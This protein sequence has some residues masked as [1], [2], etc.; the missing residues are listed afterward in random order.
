[1]NNLVEINNLTKKFN[2]I[3]GEIEAINNID[4]EIKQGEII[5]I[6]G[7]SGCGKSTLLSILAGLDKQTSGNF[8]FNGDV[9]IGYML[10]QDALL[11][12]LSIY[13][14]VLIGLKINKQVTKENLEY[15]DNLLKIY[16]LYEFKDKKPASLSGGM[17]QR[18]A[19]IRTLALK[20][21]VLLLDEPF[22]ALD[23]QTRLIIS[24]D[25]Y[26]IAKKENI[27]IIM[28]THDLAE[29]IS[30]ANKVVVLSKRPC[31]IKNVVP[32]ILNEK[33]TPINNRKDSNFSMYYD[34]IWRDL[35]VFIS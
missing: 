8:K 34:M 13:D 18:A 3:N 4:L 30:M 1:M 6:V 22:S 19:L 32:I 15:I 12:W 17:K 2:T 11:P 26:K 23:Y 7:S 21:D 33:S 27:T 29:A 9:K 5:A 28:V 35:D 20:P 14:N 25:V 24:D 31:K 10:Q 16:D